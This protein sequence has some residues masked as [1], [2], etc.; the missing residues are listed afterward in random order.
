M[1]AEVLDLSL[2]RGGRDQRLRRGIDLE[3]NSA[4]RKEMV[5]EDGGGRTL[6]SEFLQGLGQFAPPSNVISERGRSRTIGGTCVLWGGGGSVWTRFWVSRRSV[7]VVAATS[8]IV[9]EGF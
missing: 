4:G 6:G 9:N 7:D 2:K 5:T 8:R 3:D 1:S